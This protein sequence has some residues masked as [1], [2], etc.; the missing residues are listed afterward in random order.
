MIF[1][2]KLDI[3]GCLLKKVYFEKL[4]SKQFANYEMSH[5]SLKEM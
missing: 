3:K 1:F 4:Q 2:S 5:F